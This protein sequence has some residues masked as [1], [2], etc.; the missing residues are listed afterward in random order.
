VGSRQLGKQEQQQDQEAVGHHACHLPTHRA[1]SSAWQSV[2]M[3]V[4]VLSMGSDVLLH[5]IG[6]R[7]PAACFPPGC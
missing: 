3:T 4:E 5:C 1:S 7:R 6:A 2:E